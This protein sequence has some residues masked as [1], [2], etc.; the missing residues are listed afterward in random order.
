MPIIVMATRSSISVNPLDL[1]YLVFSIMY[2][3][4][5]FENFLIQDTGYN[6]LIRRGINNSLAASGGERLVNI[7]LL[8]K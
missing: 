6:I 3:V 2:F 8:A 5:F 1:R 7:S 4:Y